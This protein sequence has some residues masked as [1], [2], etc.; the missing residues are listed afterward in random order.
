MR[1][2]FSIFVALTN[3]VRPC[4]AF[5]H[6]NAIMRIEHAGIAEVRLFP[7]QTLTLTPLKGTKQ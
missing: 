2:C 1:L 4:E 6:L 5:W 7:N 3:S